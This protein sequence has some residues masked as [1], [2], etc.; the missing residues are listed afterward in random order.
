[1]AFRLI[2]GGPQFMVIDA[3]RRPLAQGDKLATTA[4]RR[5]QVVGTPL[6]VEVFDIL[7]AIWLR[8]DRI[9]ELTG[10]TFPHHD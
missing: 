4:L 1:M 8:D 5:D 7:D 2:D 10:A 6:V 3:A 9:A